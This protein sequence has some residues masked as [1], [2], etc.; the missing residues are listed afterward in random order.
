MPMPKCFVPSCKAPCDHLIPGGPLGDVP[1]C[2]THAVAWRTSTMRH[3]LPDFKKKYGPGGALFLLQKWAVTEAV[4][5]FPGATP[6][7]T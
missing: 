5:D 2:H 6:P 7:T 1:I 4:G 3:W